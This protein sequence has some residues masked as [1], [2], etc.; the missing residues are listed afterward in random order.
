MA[1]DKQKDAFM[2]VGG[3]TGMA[4]AAPGRLNRLSGCLI[5]NFPPILPPLPLSLLLSCFQNSRSRKQDLG[6]GSLPAYALWRLPQ[7]GSPA[8]RNMDGNNQTD[9]FDICISTTKVC[10]CSQ[11]ILLSFERIL[12]TFS[13]MKFEHMF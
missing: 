2:T 6:S 12:C 4:G 10:P 7:P 1:D 8:K 13:C 5:I 3:Q 9:P 11:S